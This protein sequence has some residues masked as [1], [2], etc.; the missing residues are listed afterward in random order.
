MSAL[1]QSPNQMRAVRADLRIDRPEI[2][3]GADEQI[4]GQ[5]AWTLS[6]PS[7][8]GF[9][10]RLPTKPGRL[11]VNLEPRHAVHVDDAAINELALHVVGKLPRVQ[12]LAADAGPHSLVVEN[13][14]D[15]AAAGNFGARQRRVPMLLRGRAVAHE[16]LAPFVE[17]VAP[18]IAVAGRG[19]CRIFSVRGSKMYAP[20]ASLR[21]NGPHGVS[22]VVLIEMPSSVCKQAAVGVLALAH[23]VVRVVAR[24]AVEQVDDQVGF[25][26]AVGVFDPEHPR[27]IADE[28][29]AVPELE[30]GGAVEL[31]VEH[32][33]LVGAA[34]VIG[35]FEDQKPIVRLRRARLPLRIGGHAANPQAAAVIEVE[36][37]GLGQLRKFA[38]R[39]QT[40]ALRSRRAP[41]SSWQHS[42]GVRYFSS[43]GSE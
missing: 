5:L 34:V 35:V 40:A 38:S 28:H 31:V 13:G 37:V 20:E 19:K 4:V 10:S 27:L 26:V 24:R 23:R 22:I 41:S 30:A 2:L 42:S 21:R 11:V 7:A 12:E 32:R 17:N 9:I 36:L 39:S 8:A 29:A 6:L 3:V 33:A 1:H 16:S 18:R 43:A 14:I 15:A 25:V